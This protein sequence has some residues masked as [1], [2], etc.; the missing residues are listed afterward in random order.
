MVDV[1][2]LRDILE[3]AFLMYHDQSTE[4]KRKQWSG[5]EEYIHDYCQRKNFRAAWH[6]GGSQFDSDFQNYMKKALQK[7]Q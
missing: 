6:I 7:V 3:R 2:L 1:R 5:W 4:I